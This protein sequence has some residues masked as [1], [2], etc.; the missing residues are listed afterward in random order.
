MP[1]ASLCLPAISRQMACSLST[2]R[3]TAGE[4][5][6][7]TA[8]LSASPVSEIFSIASKARP[9]SSQDSAEGGPERASS[10]VKACLGRPLR[11]CSLAATM[12]AS[13]FLGRVCS[14][15]R[16]VFSATST[17]PLA[18]AALMMRRLD[19]QEL[20]SC[21]RL[22]SALWVEWLDAQPVMS[23]ARTR[24]YTMRIAAS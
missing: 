21:A 2:S 8:F 18:S 13:S 19:S 22:A 16:A 17:E 5:L 6:V 14:S 11:V 1:C 15:F 7:S 9:L 4:G 10:R 3:I 24:Q 23:R 20:S 12:R